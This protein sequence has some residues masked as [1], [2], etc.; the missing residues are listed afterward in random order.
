MVDAVAVSQRQ[1]LSDHPAH[2]QAEDVRPFDSLGVENADGVGHH[3]GDGERITDGVRPS[4][5]AIAHA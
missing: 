4:G 3:V 2:R 5:A 1:L